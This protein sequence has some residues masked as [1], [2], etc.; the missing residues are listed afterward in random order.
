MTSKTEGKVD[1][2]HMLVK[3][4]ARLRDNV[5]VNVVQEVTDTVQVRCKSLWCGC[6]QVACWGGGGAGGSACC[7]TR[8]GAAL[9]V[10]SFVRVCPTMSGKCASL[11]LLVSRVV[12]AVGAVSSVQV[13]ETGTHI[14]A[15][16]IPTGIG[17]VR[18]MNSSS[19]NAAVG[20]GCSNSRIQQDHFACSG[21][22]GGAQ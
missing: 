3:Y 20:S 19:V 22:S 2:S 7:G 1:N 5:A 15:G 11:F 16:A 8:V 6:V 18:Q 10:R 21:C 9:A 14:S 17:K 12:D 13:A 4:D